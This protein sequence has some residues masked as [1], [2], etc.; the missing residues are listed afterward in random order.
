MGGLKKELGPMSSR[1][2]RGFRATEGSTESSALL[3]GIEAVLRPKAAKKSG[4]WYREVEAADFFMARLHRGE[5]EK[6]WLR[7]VAQDAKSGDKGRGR[8]GGQPY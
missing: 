8:G 4:K 3:F 7:H 5:V 1:R 6:N 2:T